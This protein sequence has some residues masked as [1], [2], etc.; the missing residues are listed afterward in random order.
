[1]SMKPAPPK[2]A[3]RKADP[4]NS[5]FEDKAKTLLKYAMSQRGANYA[6]LA[7]ALAAIGVTI[8]A[9]GLENKVSRGGFSAAF[10]LQCMEALEINL[11]SLPR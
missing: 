5:E 8:S 2:P 10:L 9:R 11:T 7:E 4:V 3:A 6:A 1:M